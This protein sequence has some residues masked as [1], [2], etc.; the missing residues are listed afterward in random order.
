MARLSGER[1]V[2]GRAGGG[3]GGLLGAA[4]LVPIAASS[5][6]A[7]VEPSTALAIAVDGFHLLA[8]GVWAGGLLPLAFLLRASAREEGAVPPPYALLPARCFPG[9]PLP[10]ALALVLSSAT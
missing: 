8:T 7:A 6:A 5:H 2:A 1:R 4:A 9:L 3:G 10:A